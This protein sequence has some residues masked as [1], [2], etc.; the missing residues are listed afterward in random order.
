M[1]VSKPLFLLFYVLFFSLFQICLVSLNYAL[2]ISHRYSILDL[3]LVPVLDVFCF[4]KLFFRSFVH[5]AFASSVFFSETFGL[6]GRMKLHRIKKSTLFLTLCLLPL[7]TFYTFMGLLS[8][9]FYSILMTA[10]ILF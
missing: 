1:Y 6:V 10:F 8:F 4:T 5:R 9:N 2:L 3:D 7:F